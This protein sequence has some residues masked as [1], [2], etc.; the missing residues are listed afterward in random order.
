MISRERIRDEHDLLQERFIDMKSIYTNGT[1]HILMSCYNEND[2]NVVG[3][4]D[5]MEA[6]LTY[7]AR[8]IAIEHKKDDPRDVL[9]LVARLTAYLVD[10]A[11]DNECVD[12]RT[13]YWYCEHELLGFKKEEGVNE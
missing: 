5:S 1:V 3:V 8:K 7:F 9:E 6:L 4:F 2:N 12:G 13:R 10:N 11:C